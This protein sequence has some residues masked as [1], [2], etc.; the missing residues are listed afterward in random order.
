MNAL[1]SVVLAVLVFL[2][3]M[4]ALFYG[5]TRE[6]DGAQNASRATDN[7]QDRPAQSA[8]GDV[9]AEITT[10]PLPSLARSLS[11]AKRG[12]GLGAS[13]DAFGRPLDAVAAQ[14]KY[15]DLGSYFVFTDDEML[16]YLTFDLGY[17]NGYTPS[18]LDTLLEKN[19]KATFF[20][21]QEYIDDAPLIV[22]RIIDEGHT[23]GNHTVNH[24]SMPDVS[25]ERAKQEINQ[26]HDNVLKEYG[27]KM[28]L[29]RYPMG[30]YSEKSM[31]LVYG[32]GYR[33]IFWSFAYKD[34]LTDAQPDPTASLKRVTDA[35]HPGAIYLLHAV[36]S[37]NDAIMGDF[38]DSA[39]EKGYEFALVDEKLGLV[40]RK[41]SPDE[42]QSII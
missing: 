24:P 13:T 25:D 10:K 15:K 1:R 27:Y 23:L 4:A 35:L 19:V 18:I 11:G 12:W 2:V 17:E 36:S 14:E 16:V 20:V 6:A 38:I 26:L 5:I 29:F 9:P 8:P 30:E 33:S 21:T 42:T 28:Q 37:T 41:P 22:K 31:S 34:W 32:L 3:L 40:E 7:I 39:R